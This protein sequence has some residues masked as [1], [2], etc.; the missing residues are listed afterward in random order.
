[1]LKPETSIGKSSSNIIRY[2]SYRLWRITNRLWENPTCSPA[3]P[4]TSSTPTPRPPSAS[5][6]RPSSSTSTARK[7]KPR[8]ET[9][10]A[11]STSGPSPPPTTA[12]PSCP[13]RLRH[14]P[15]SASISS[16]S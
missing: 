12:A 9:P 6:S 8:S 5:S 11:R 15:P 16:S 4:V 10:S 2:A 3:S 13:R 14:H 1:M 7:S